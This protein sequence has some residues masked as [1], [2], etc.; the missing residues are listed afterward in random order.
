MNSESFNNI[1]IPKYLGF[2]Y[3]KIFVKYPLT[4]KQENLLG[5]L[6]KYAKLGYL[7]KCVVKISIK[8]GTPKPIIKTFIDAKCNYK[9]HN[10]VI[11]RKKYFES[12]TLLLD[13]TIYMIDNTNKRKLKL[14]SILD[15]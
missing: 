5:K 11:T 1:L 9:R 10:N 3:A 15:L 7:T 4:K 13:T 2:S 14:D 8:I 6:P 12:L